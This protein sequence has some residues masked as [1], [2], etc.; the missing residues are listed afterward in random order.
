MRRDDVMELMAEAP[1]VLAVKNDE[2]MRCCLES[3]NRVV[4]VLYGDVC[5]VAGI[6]AAAKDAGKV[7]F[8]H[9]DLIEGLAN[10]TSAV[11]FIAEQTRAD[12]I[13]STK[14]SLIR[15]AKAKGLLTV[16][17]FFL[18]D[19]MALEN[20][21]RQMEQGFADFIEVLPGAMPK[22]IRELVRSEKTPVIAGGLIRDKEDVVAL[23]SA[24]AAAVSSTNEFIWFL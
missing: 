5:A 6:V 16:Q 19:S 11:D 21:A 23:L 1:V 15:H 9:L 14:Q 20:A 12:G 3:E 22:I 8:V 24:G 2:G 18:I 17:R 7:V 13:I 10:H 4:F